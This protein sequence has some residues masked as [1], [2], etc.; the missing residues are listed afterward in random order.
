LSLKVIDVRRGRIH[1][2]PTTKTINAEATSAE[3]TLTTSCPDSNPLFDNREDHSASSSHHDSTLD[4]EVDPGTAM[5]LDGV[6]ESGPAETCTLPVQSEHN[7]QLFVPEI[8]SDSPLTVEDIYIEAMTLDAE[9]R[10][11]RRNLDA[12][13]RGELSQIINFCRDALH[14]KLLL[15]SVEQAQGGLG[16]GPSRRRCVSSENLASLLGDSTRSL[17]L[18]A[19]TAV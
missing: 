4:S 2:E 7:Q 10:V 6:A 1:S 5:S 12:A 18:I 3:R 9:I 11:F 8:V 15:R 17:E 13:G 19:E 14:R 16:A